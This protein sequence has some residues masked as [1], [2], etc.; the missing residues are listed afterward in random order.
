ME[1]FEVAEYLKRNRE[2]EKALTHLWSAEDESKY[3]PHPHDGSCGLELENGRVVQLDSLSNHAPCCDSSVGYSLLGY[4][5]EVATLPKAVSHR[6]FQTPIKNQE[7]RGTCVSFAACALLEALYLRE[8]VTLDLSEQFTNMILQASIH[9]NTCAEGF[10]IPGAARIISQEGIC[11]E[12]LCP[13]ED[14][15]E[16]ARACALRPTATQLKE[17]VYKLENYTFF[18]TSHTGADKDPSN[19]HFLVSLVAQG[20]DVFIGVGVAWAGAGSNWGRSIIDVHL[21]RN[22]APIRPR[23]AHAL[24]ITGYDS[25]GAVPYFEIKNSWGRGVGWDGYYR[26]SYDYMH[27]YILGA[28]I[29]MLRKPGQVYSERS[30]PAG[31]SHSMKTETKQ[32]V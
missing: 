18:N 10:S 11:L 13:Y 23:G 30:V 28:A 17:A 4:E 22:G 21:D 14:K 15:A 9:R 25:S 20:Y 5:P 8:K 24:L 16:T 12:T 26:L 32:E 27:Q 19:P 6:T 31:A 3:I 29:G 1:N 2:K 7:D